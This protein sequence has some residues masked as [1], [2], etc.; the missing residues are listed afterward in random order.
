[1][2]GTISDYYSTWSGKNLLKKVFKKKNVQK[3]Q[4]TITLSI[5]VIKKSY[6][7]IPTA[8]VLHKLQL[9]ILPEATSIPC[10]K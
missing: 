1:M 8:S 3:N 7:T 6:T 10:N 9:P 5:H 2:Y 4:D